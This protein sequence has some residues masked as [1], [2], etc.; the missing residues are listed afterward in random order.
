MGPNLQ[1][2][3]DCVRKENMRF[4]DVAYPEASKLRPRRK[5]QSGI[6]GPGRVKILYAVSSTVWAFAVNDDESL[7]RY[8][9]TS[10]LSIAI[11]GRFEEVQT[12]VVTHRVD[13]IILPPVAHSD[14]ADD[15]G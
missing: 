9:L 13:V 14:D 12:M 10:C 6:H 1:I 2:S 7:M 11:D 4:A 5:K 15:D 3:T 8:R